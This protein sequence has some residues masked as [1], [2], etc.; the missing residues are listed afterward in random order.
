MGIF[1]GWLPSCDIFVTNDLLLRVPWRIGHMCLTH[2]GDG[3]LM[4]K[5]STV[6]CIVLYWSPDGQTVTV[7]TTVY[8]IVLYWSSDDQTMVVVT[9]VRFIVL[10]WSSDGQTMVWGSTEGD[11]MSINMNTC[12]RTSPP[13]GYGCLICKILRCRYLYFDTQMTEKYST[14]MCWVFDMPNPSI[15]IFCKT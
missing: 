7:T 12:G 1:R 10:Y 4:V 2:S 3:H 6:Y 8:C 9:I 11:G 14:A 15:L 13:P 5:P